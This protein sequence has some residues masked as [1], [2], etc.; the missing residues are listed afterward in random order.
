MKNKS[1]TYNFLK[2]LVYK[3]YNY[4]FY[5]K[6]QLNFLYR[7]I[8]ILPLFNFQQNANSQRITRNDSIF[9][10]KALEGKVV[11][12]E[13]VDGDTLL[14]VNLR[15][16]TIRPPFKFK[17][18]RQKKRY[19]R[20]VIYVKKVYPYSQLVSEQLKDIHLNLENYKTKKEQD[21]YIKLKEKEL[22][23]QFEG[24]LRKLTFTQGK[25]LIK[26]IDRETGYTTYEIVKE[27][28]GSINAFFWQSVARIF[29]S[30]LKMEYDAK[31]DDRMI[32][33]IVIRIENGEL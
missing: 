33:D 11:R 9:I 14:H 3:L 26:L 13:I 23:Q 31:G 32:E 12:G 7:I 10:I 25:I 16:I 22:K 6:K 17:S 8:L 4:L 20:L 15:A 21:K 27:L 2:R 30:N 28:K 18:K 29:G 24:Q 5:K 19:S 1:I